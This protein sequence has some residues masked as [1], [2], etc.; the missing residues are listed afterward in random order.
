MEWLK[1]LRSDKPK[2]C[3]ECGR[4]QL[5]D[6]V[7]L[8]RGSYGQVEIFF[9][10][11]PTLFCG[12]PGHARRFVDPD[13]GA[14]LI[15][16]VFWQKYVPLGRPGVRAKVKCLQCGKNLTKESD[17]LGQVWGVLEIKDTSP[18]NIRIQGPLTICPRCHTEQLKATREVGRDVS[19]AFVDAFKRIRLEP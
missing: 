19:N 7:P 9:E 5:L 13:F 10:D 16:A 18:F 12:Q 4:E 8:L 17:H 14:R 11:L 6:V 15:D 1:R 3:S 2:I